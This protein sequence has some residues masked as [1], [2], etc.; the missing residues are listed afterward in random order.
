MRD[1]QRL[2]RGARW[3]YWRWTILRSAG[4]AYDDLD[5]LTTPQA[6]HAVD[7]LLDA[8]ALATTAR[9]EAERLLEA[10]AP[11]NA[12]IERKRARSE[13]LRKLRAGHVPTKELAIL[14]GAER[15]ALAAW[16]ESDGMVAAA[17]RSF[18]ETFAAEL[19]PARKTLRALAEDPRVR[20]ATLWQSP[21]ALA[22]LDALAH[23][24]QPERNRKVRQREQLAAL[25]L[26]RYLAK[27]D[28][29]GFFGPRAWG[30]VAAQPDAMRFRSDEAL[31]D[32]RDLYFEFW[33]L[34]LLGERI[35]EDPEVRPHLR[36]IRS[37]R[38]AVDGTTL[39]HPVDQRAE[40]PAAYARLLRAAD[41]TRTTI[42]IAAELADGTDEGFA[43]L[44]EVLE[45]LSELGAQGLVAE[46]LAV[47]TCD[48]H[49]EARLRE[50]IERL[51]TEL[52]ERWRPAV[53]GLEHYRERLVAA[54]GAE[55][56][57]AII[58]ELNQWFEQVTGRSSTRGE[59][60]MYAARALLFEDCT[61]A[62]ELDLGEAF[63]EKIAAPL[64]LVLVSARWYLAE[65]GHRV[66]A[67]AREIHQ[68]LT[69]ETGEAAVDYLRF[70]LALEPK[71]EGLPDAVLV[72]IQK[73]WREVLA[74]PEGASRVERTARELAPH[75][76]AAFGDAR[77]V[78][79]SARFHSPDLMIAARD[80]EAVRRGDYQVVV[81]EV[82][83]GWNSICYPVSLKQAK[84][85]DA[86]VRAFANDLPACFI[87]PSIANSE[88]HRAIRFDFVAPGVVELA[89]SPGTV[90]RFPPSQR[91]DI[92]ELVV[93][94]GDGG[95]LVVRTRDGRF[96]TDLAT[97]ID[98]PL[99]IGRDL[100]LLAGP[101]LPRVTIDGVVIQREAWRL[102][103]LAID[104]KEEPFVAVR[105]WARESGLPRRLF[106]K[107]PEE[108]KPF[109]VDLECP[110]LVEVF[111]RLAARTAGMAVSEM[112]PGPD[113]LW[114]TDAAGRH[115][116]S[117]AR[118]VAV[119]PKAL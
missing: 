58:T 83:V 103:A 39:H 55:Q 57:G 78:W 112:M 11:P 63:L 56:R 105:R 7:A 89:T 17:R 74:L 93:V 117:E 65:L 4:F 5:R 10:A 42:A 24:G 51:P 118:L 108:T 34:G 3:P 64:E 16:R 19:A 91:I 32:R 14:D 2:A 77:P 87:A 38:V 82:H 1:H 111:A 102:P 43:D 94:P 15:D 22:G 101:H 41:G 67:H 109:L 28:A 23:D 81:G 60:K 52:A 88:Y 62:I 61:R 85:P 21:N 70:W 29:I 97:V 46:R 44:A 79:P 106:V 8:E 90:S 113:E 40:L 99:R 114:L 30:T 20:E 96:T 69:A 110:F 48:Y 33:P 104:D 95:E 27:N 9:L 59:G 72:E 84:E 107:L 54:T 18:D 115:Y 36:P 13:A 12:P 53:D 75:I 119:D 76:E 100:R 66:L 31:L 80:A 49:P 6:A 25:Y 37:P 35:A 71:L 47:P 116:T 50:E 68:R 98:A 45:A 86:I 92:G 26:Q 73:V